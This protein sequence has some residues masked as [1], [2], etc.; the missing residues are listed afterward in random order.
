MGVV[1]RAEDLALKRLVNL[2]AMQPH[3]AAA[4]ETTRERYLR[5]AQT[6]AAVQHDNIVT[7]HQ[8]GQDS[9][10][11]FLAM[12]CARLGRHDEA[13]ALAADLH[14]SRRTEQRPD[15][16]YVIEATRLVEMLSGAASGPDAAGGDAVS[17]GGG[18][19]PPR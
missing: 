6:T 17:P 19:S 14:D 1:F 7:I 3:V 4:H 5:E 12:A 18:A 15:S 10:V 13:R 16:P 11:A 2:K 9:D 8:V